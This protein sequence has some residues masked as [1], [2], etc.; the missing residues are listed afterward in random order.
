MDGIFDPLHTSDIELL[1]RVMMAQKPFLVLTEALQ[2][3]L[4]RTWRDPLDQEVRSNFRRLVDPPASTDVIMD[5]PW[6]PL[7]LGC[8]CGPA[9]FERRHRESAP[10][11]PAA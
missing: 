3:E 8:R 7:P 9:E 10:L 5:V 6:A 2:Q 1:G 11:E 4:L